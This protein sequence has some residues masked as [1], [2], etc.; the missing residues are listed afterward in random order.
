MRLLLFIYNNDNKNISTVQC[1]HLQRLHD[2]PNS[3]REEDAVHHVHQAAPL[4]RGH[5]SPQHVGA[6][7]GDDLDIA[8]DVS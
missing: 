7:D 6:V 4:R 3:G 1:V 8:D 2:V 5:V